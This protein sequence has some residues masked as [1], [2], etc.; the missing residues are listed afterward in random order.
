VTSGKRDTD[1]S[2]SPAVSVVLPVYNGA[3]TIA[4]TI[5]SVLQ[6][7][8]SDFELIVINDGSTDQTL[9]IIAEF[10]DARV[11]VYSFERGPLA[12]GRNRGIRL[13]EGEFI[14]FIDADDLWATDKL[15]CQVS[16]LRS[17]PE[18]MLVY[19]WSDLIDEDDYLLNHGSHVRFE[20]NVF[21]DLLVSCFL[22]N[23]SNALIRTI[24]LDHVGMFDETR[25][26][27]EDWDMWLRIAYKFPVVNVPVVQVFYRVHG[28]ALSSNTER[29]ESE[30]RKVV[31]AAL[32]RMPPSA[33]KDEIERNGERHLYLYLAGRVAQT[34]TGFACGRMATGYLRKFWAIKP[35]RLGYLPRA[36][37]LLAKIGIVSLL[38][39]RASKFVLKVSLVL[40]GRYRKIS[41][42]AGNR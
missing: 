4:D 6:Q 16:R 28:S 13:A 23:G 27:A 2:S 19:S 40:R 30:C 33:E 38:P 42:S 12:G 9:D 41:I 22:D 25:T 39:G 21:K 17:S 7:T 32:S 11:S 10:S 20:G 8:F 5:A 15:A 35:L 26:A 3:K 34:N 18:A 1:G 24:V 31:I 36:L 29:Q 14:A 37:A